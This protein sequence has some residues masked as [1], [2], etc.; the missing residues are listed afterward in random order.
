IAVMGAKGAV[1]VLYNN[2]FQ[3]DRETFLAE[4]EREY[5]ELVA[6]PLVAAKRGYIDDIIEP[7]RTR[8]RIINALKLLKDKVDSNPV[9]KHGNIPL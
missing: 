7:A 4:R 6:N 3:E 1:E 5:T 2:Y 9:K 8:P